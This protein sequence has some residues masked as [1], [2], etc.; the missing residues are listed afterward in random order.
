MEDF[1]LEDGSH[2]RGPDSI[3]AAYPFRMTARDM[4]RFGL[5]YLRGGQ[6]MVAEPQGK[7]GSSYADVQRFP[8][9]ATVFPLAASTTPVVVTDLMI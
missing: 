3:H 1:R 2:V 6:L 7:Y 4:A 9:G 8:R 5:L